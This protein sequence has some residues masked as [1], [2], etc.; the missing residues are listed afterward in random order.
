MTWSAMFLAAHAGR[1]H[2]Q[3]RE[4]RAEHD[5]LRAAGRF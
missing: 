2:R 5:A 3:A 1:E 4:R